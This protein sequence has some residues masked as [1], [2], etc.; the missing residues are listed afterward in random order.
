MTDP[1]E[2]SSAV[3]RSPTRRSSWF[4][5]SAVVVAAVT[6]GQVSVLGLLVSATG[7]I[8]F[9]VGLFRARERVVTFGAAVVVTGA[10]VAGLEGSSIGPV[11]IAATAGVLAWDFA[12][13]AIDLG[14]QLGRETDTGRIET[15]HAFGS[16]LVGFVTIVVGYGV[17]LSATENQPT[18]AVV[19][20]LVSATVLAAA[21]K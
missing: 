6:V 4:G 16:V 7:G 10:L 8:V 21:L 5:L 11:L 20:L 19:L 17:Y 14:E 15:V 1:A 9:A 3:T 2:R 12:T 18:V 13:V